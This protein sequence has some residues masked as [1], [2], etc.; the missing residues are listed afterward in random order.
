MLINYLKIA[1]RNLIK[2]KASAFIIITG[3]AAGI[4]A[5]I[6]IAL[7]IQSEISYDSY[8]KNA[9]LIYRINTEFRFPD[10]N[11]RIARNSMAFGPQFKEIYPGINSYLRIFTAGKQTVRYEDKIFNETNVCFADSTL[12][13][14]FD[15]EIVAGT[16]SA[17]NNPG[18]I[19]IHEDKA[20]VYFGNSQSAIDKILKFQNSEY[21]VTAVFKNPG[22]THIPYEFYIS[23]SSLPRPFV[24][25]AMWDYMWMVTNTY[26]KVNPGITDSEIKENLNSFFHTRV[27]PWLKENNVQGS[28][29]YHS[30][31]LKKIHLDN[32]WS[33]DFPTTSNPAYISIFFAAGIFILII[34]CFNYLNLITARSMKRAKEVGLR[35]V[36][37]ADRKQLI[38]QFMGESTLVTFISFLAAFAV[39]SVLI[40]LF[41]EMTGKNFSEA[42]VVSSE[43]IL[44]MLVIF[45]FIS[46]IAGSYPAFYLSRFQP[47]DVLKS[48]SL[49]FNNKGKFSILKAVFSPTGLRK[50]LVVL[51]FAISIILIIATVIIYRQFSFMKDTDLGFNKDQVLVID[52]P[53]DTSVSASLQTIRHELM[54]NPSVKN[55]SAVS[56]VP[57]TA[58]GTLYFNVEQPGKMTDKFLNFIIVDDEYLK[59][60]E[61]PVTD[62]RNFSREIASDTVEAFII[63]QT[64]AKQLGWEQPLDKKMMNGL[65]Y[66]GKVVGLIKDF[67][68]NS[69][70]NPISPLVLMY[71]PVTQGYL[72][73]KIS[74]SGVEST[75]DYIK[76][77][78]SRFDPG[79]PFDY[80]FLDDNFDKVYQKEKNTL[81]VFSYF[82]LI[83]IIIS[84]MGLFGLASFIAEQK[85]KEIGIR[86]V[87]GASIPS[88]AGL[89]SK[90]FLKLVLISNI[91]A[92]PVAY[93]AASKWLED[94][95]YRIDISI[96]IFLFA[97][98]AAFLIALVTVSWQSIRAAMSNPVDSLKYE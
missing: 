36:L 81:Q 98:A 65:G 90:D 20:K 91:I 9:D 88:I 1:F 95:A 24:E 60:M 97:G 34:A 47:V 3:L 4:S 50:L 51:Q 61:I 52:I 72:L 82:A 14:F 94:F 32:T 38:Y 86:K 75:I 63:N 58:T 57:G 26:I 11:E 70:H 54:R 83:A 66:D 89:L 31:P 85:T 68:Y 7:Y 69:L 21:R 42:S 22:F 56:H 30:Q 43:I 10:Q 8:H 59:L 73:V 71:A 77:T 55:A 93:W 25:Q 28:L 5:C 64:A 18:S 44:P 80:F 17:L 12:F 33:Y 46:I 48:G 41:N 45:I 13:D 29:I 67:H 37:G 92:V 74:S 79:H 40:P 49:P 23:F 96:W 62:G 84:C 53:N 19:I 16:K 78:W 6:L 87:L 2:Q 27:E 39:I 15:Y 76:E 35:K